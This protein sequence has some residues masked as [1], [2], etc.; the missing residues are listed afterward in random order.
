MAEIVEVEVVSRRKGE[1]FECQMCEVAWI[2]KDPEALTN[3][4]K[5][6]RRC[7]NPKCRSMRWDREKYPH[8][9]PP[10]PPDPN[11]GGGI[12]RSTDADGQSAPRTGR[13]TCYRT[14]RGLQNSG[15]VLSSEAEFLATRFARANKSDLLVRARGVGASGLAQLAAIRRGISVAREQHHFLGEISRQ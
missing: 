9:R 2:P 11:G 3:P 15:S 5:R 1:G 14:L 10:K 4:A 6:P 12:S 7:A 8:A 13:R